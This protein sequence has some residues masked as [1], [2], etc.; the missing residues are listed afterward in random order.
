[1]NSSAVAFDLPADV[2]FADDLDVSHNPDDY[3]DPAPPLPLMAG[4]YG[5][6]L[7]AGLKRERDDQGNP[8]DKI[9]LV[10]NSAGVPTYPV[11][12]VKKVTVATPEDFANRVAFP[13][14]EFSTKPGTRKD[15]NAGGQEYPYNHLSDI[16]RSHDATMGYRGLEEGIRLLQ[17]LITDGAVFHVKI[18]W[19]AED[20]SWIGEQVKAVQAQLEAGEI[21]EADAKKTMNEIRYKKGRLEG[22]AKFVQNGPD[23][24][25]LVP[26]WEGPGGEMIPARPFIREWV[27]TLNLGKP[28]YKLGARKVV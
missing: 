1:M 9:V 8:T 22:I 5:V 23:G 2:T 14:Q 10:K 12:E 7:E 16:I 6:R 20:R 28:G 24:K 21:T 26:E 11:V 17:S 27:S 25:V 3:R 15:F 18:D 19:R 13:Y 4:I